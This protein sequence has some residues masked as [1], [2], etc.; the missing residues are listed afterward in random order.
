MSINPGWE[1]TQRK[2]FK[3]LQTINNNKKIFNK[4]ARGASESNLN[5][6]FGSCVP[7]APSFPQQASPAPWTRS[8]QTTPRFLQ[9]HQLSFLFHGGIPYSQSWDFK[10][11][12]L[13]WPRTASRPYLCLPPWQQQHRKLLKKLYTGQSILHS[14]SRAPS[15]PSEL[16]GTRNNLSKLQ[17]LSL[18]LS[19][20]VHLVQN[21]HPHRAAEKFQKQMILLDEVAAKPYLG[22]WTRGQHKWMPY[23]NTTV[24]ARMRVNAFGSGA[25]VCH[26]ALG[27]M[28]FLL[29]KAFFWKSTANG[30]AEWWGWSVN[31]TSEMDQGS[32]STVRNSYG[33]SLRI[34]LTEESLACDEMH[35]L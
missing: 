2:R 18:T 17:H 34:S 15:V 1:I 26:Q 30:K 8:P 16:R 12:A 7:H 21:L 20:T 5:A 24:Y 11:G 19:Q 27:H 23:S 9:I 14:Q 4:I 29:K 22:L 3:P 33:R 32:K 31:M 10:M 35:R 6:D 25:A 28:H 13:L